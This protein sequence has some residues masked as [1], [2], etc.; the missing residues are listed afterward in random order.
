MLFFALKQNMEKVFIFRQKPWSNPFEKMQI[1]ALFLIDFF[2]I[3][4]KLLFVLEY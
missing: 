4:I 2:A 1:I 3:Q